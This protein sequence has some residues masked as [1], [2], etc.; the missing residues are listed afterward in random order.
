MGIL[1][2]LKDG[3]V[4]RSAQQTRAT[5]QSLAPHLPEACIL[6]LWG[7]LGVGKSTFVSGLARAWGINQP[8]TSPTFNLFH[9]YEG[10]RRLVHLDAYRIDDLATLDH[11]MLED[12]LIPPY[13]LV[14]E[15][16][17]QIEAWLPDDCWHLELEILEAG[18]HQIQL[19]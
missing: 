7:D 16:P 1:K 9:L 4:T 18:K 3:V 12:F 19:R 15:W 11:L 17:S 2:Q 8:T 10:S 14:I 5:A 6:A 13:C